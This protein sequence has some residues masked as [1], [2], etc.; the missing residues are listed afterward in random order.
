M[1]AE[2]YLGV[3]G[4]GS[5]TDQTT[6]NPKL[7]SMVQLNFPA[8]FRLKPLRTA[9]STAPAAAPGEIDEEQVVTQ[10]SRGLNMSTSPMPLSANNAGRNI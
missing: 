5:G 1:E 2:H 4:A 9:N 10:G 6:L 3:A 7:A 8:A